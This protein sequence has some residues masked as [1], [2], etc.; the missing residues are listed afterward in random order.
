MDRVGEEYYFLTKQ[1]KDFGSV[2][3]MLAM[4]FA[5]LVWSVFV[6]KVFIQGMIFSSSV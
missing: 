5:F 4:G 1:V 3:V 2:A 6:F